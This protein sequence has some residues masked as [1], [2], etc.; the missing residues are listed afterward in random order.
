[1]H[2]LS[3]LASPL[4]C[5]FISAIVFPYPTSA[6]D[7]TTEQGEAQI[8]DPTVECAPYQYPP[9]DDAQG[10]FPPSWTVA[11][12]LSNDSD[13][14]ARYQ[15][16]EG[17]IPKIPPKGRKAD[18]ANGNFGGFKY[19]PNDP[20]CWWTYSMCTTPNVSG[21]PDDIAAV[22]EPN[23]L[24]YGFDD[25][26]NCSHNAFYDY[27][28]SNDQKATMFYIGS[29]VQQFP[30]E[31]QRALADGHQICVHTWSHHYMTALT[32]DEA[33]AELWYSMQIIKLV[34]GV[35]PTCWRPP[36]GDVDNRIRA[37]ANALG[38]MTIM[39]QFDSE[40]WLGI[41]SVTK[42][43]NNYMDL[44]TAA[45]NGTFSTSGTIMLTHELTNF[46]MSEAVSFY[47]Q[48]ASA[49]SYLVPVGVALNV[50]APYVE[51]GYTLP[52]FA[53]YIGGMHVVST[54]GSG[55]GGGSTSAPSVG[56]SSDGSGTSGS[57]TT[58]NSTNTSKSGAAKVSLKRVDSFA[59]A[60]VLVTGILFML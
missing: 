2:L 40:D 51:D 49:F 4:S 42:V 41:E 20:D 30:L 9:V 16:I 21:V 10:N 24:G 12:I 37:I 43:N 34:V 26:P 5:L 25:G 29:N 14:Q 53:Q 55:S 3:F 32:N 54:T 59:S 60:A 28:L 13:A 57:T 22:P 45:Q 7:R 23:T 58:G 38:L 46:T 47:D 33:F 6:Q 39:W 44:I 18:S 50:T 31:A 52:S 48:V 1:M 19:D 27:L 35:T 17:L 15:S 56:G 36:Y 11:T 8:L